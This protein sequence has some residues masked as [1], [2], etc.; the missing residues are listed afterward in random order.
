MRNYPPAPT[1]KIKKRSY[2]QQRLQQME[3]WEGHQWT[4]KTAVVEV[5]EVRKF[6]PLYGL[7]ILELQAS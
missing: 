1:D 5:A 7:N 2:F 6:R 3:V 4:G